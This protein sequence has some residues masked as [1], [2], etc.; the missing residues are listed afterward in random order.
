MSDRS[1]AS[2]AATSQPY[3]P[4]SGKGRKRSSQ[5]PASKRAMQLRDSQRLHRE[6]KA[7]YLKDLEDQVKHLTEE[8]KE[9]LQLKQRIAELELKCT[10][11]ETQ[12]VGTQG[13]LQNIPISGLPCSNC[14]MERLKNSIS[15]NQISSLESQLLHLRQECDRLTVAHSVA[16]FLPNSLDAFFDSLQ[17]PAVS[18]AAP[19]VKEELVKL[20]EYIRTEMKSLPSIH[21]S[22]LIDKL[23]ELFNV[24]VLCLMEFSPLNETIHATA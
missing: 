18:T 4:N 5:E 13:V 12:V 8:N 2:P 14:A 16:S 7:K 1:S 9:V 15:S 3:N 19:I 21:D 22:P 24:S 20:F 11:L 6:R 10:I 23:N 17:T